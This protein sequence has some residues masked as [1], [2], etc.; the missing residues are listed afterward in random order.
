V[1]Q[2]GRDP[3]RGLRAIA[4]ATLLLEALVLL[5]ALL[6][7]AGL[8]HGSRV[9][10]TV[11]LLGLVALCVVGSGL[12]RRRVGAPLGLLV[13]V[14]VV[15]AGALVWPLY[16]LGVVFGALWLGYLRLRRE[17]PVAPATLA[18]PPP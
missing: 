2:G 11:A 3:G 5:L 8:H 17:L 6:G 15:A 16:P 9:P 4:A 12:L 18:P 7:Y 14:L 10:G 13:Q 1:S